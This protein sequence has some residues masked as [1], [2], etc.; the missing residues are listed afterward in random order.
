MI[1]ELIK[2]LTREQERQQS[3]QRIKFL[4]SL[5]QNTFSAIYEECELQEWPGCRFNGIYY[6]EI[7]IYVASLARDE[8]YE[9]LI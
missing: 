1:G 7:E 8:G 3:D 5:P 9:Q 4:T 6:Y 2:Q